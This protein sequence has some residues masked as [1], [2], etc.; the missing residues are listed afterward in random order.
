MNVVDILIMLIFGV[1]GYFMKKFEY[2]GAPL[3]LA[4]ILAPM[5]ETAL[6]QSLIVSRGEFGIF[7]HRP[8]SL[9]AL[10]TAVIFLVMP[11]IPFLR[12]KRGKWVAEEQSEWSGR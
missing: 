9:A 11:L 10:G 6:R 1:F 8:Y 4:F 2:D 5:M 3:V 12:K 7:I